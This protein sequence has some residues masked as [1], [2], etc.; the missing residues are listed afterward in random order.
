MRQ[1]RD[2]RGVWVVVAERGGTNIWFFCDPPECADDLQ[3]DGAHLR[4]IAVLGSVSHLK[5]STTHV[6]HLSEV[7][8][9]L[10]VSCCRVLYILPLLAQ[11]PRFSGDP[12]KVRE[13]HQRSSNLAVCLTFQPR[14]CS[15]F[16][17]W[18]TFCQ[19]FSLFFFWN[20]DT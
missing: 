12:W 16:P 20:L 4:H 9:T 13:S 8:H 17:C 18:F 19:K 3:S 6:S 5:S 2:G 7:C 14:N 15:Q 11:R 1:T 10:C